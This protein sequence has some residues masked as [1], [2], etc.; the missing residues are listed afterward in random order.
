[1]KRVERSL[2][3]DDILLEDS[4]EYVVENI[5]DHK[6]VKNALWY[7]VKWQGQDDTHN[8]WEPT[9]QFGNNH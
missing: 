8:T 6:K 5:L 7:H 9:R 1:V 3:N 4:D 2:D